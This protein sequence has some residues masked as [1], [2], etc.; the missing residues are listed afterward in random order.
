MLH[1]RLTTLTHWSDLDYTFGMHTGALSEMVWKT[2]NVLLSSIA[3]LLEL[4]TEFMSQRAEIYAKVL[5]DTGCPLDCIFGFID[6]TKVQ[7][8]R[9]GGHGELQRACYSGEKR[10]DC[11]IYQA[12]TTPDGLV[13]PLY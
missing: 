8:S 3:P 11:L 10:F 5:H 9:T 4:R 6:S 12:M 7:V 2:I 13:F 1:M